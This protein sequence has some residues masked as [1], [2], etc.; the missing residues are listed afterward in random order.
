MQVACALLKSKQ[1]FKVILI[2][3]LEDQLK[4]AKSR[5]KA[6][7][8]SED[9]MRECGEGSDVQKK[10]KASSPVPEPSPVPLALRSGDVPG[11]DREDDDIQLAS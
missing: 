5:L 10:K 1:E 11:G 9:P 2:D 3:K 4:A 8:Q 6:G 7:L